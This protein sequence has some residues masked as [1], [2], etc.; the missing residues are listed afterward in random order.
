MRLC[1]LHMLYGASDIILIFTLVGGDVK[2]LGNIDGLNQWDSLTK[3]LPSPRTEI[4]L[5]IDRRNR[6]AGIRFGNYKLLKINA[7]QNARWYT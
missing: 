3:N 4:L 2:A 1:I 5:N 6:E 7:T